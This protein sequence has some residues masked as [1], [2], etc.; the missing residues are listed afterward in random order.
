MVIFV[1]D[2]PSAKN[3]DPE[4]PFVGTKSMKNLLDWMY[5]L[6]VD[7]NNVLV[8]NRHQIHKNGEIRVPGLTSSYLPGDRII[9]LGNKASKH[10]NE[11]T[12][13]HFKLPHPSGLN[14][15]LNDEKF[16]KSELNRCKEWLNER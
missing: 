10:L 2:E 16:I 13:G 11:L 3:K 12:F 4:V 8:C 14:R 6:E 15:K 7:V 1:G 9:A 5:I